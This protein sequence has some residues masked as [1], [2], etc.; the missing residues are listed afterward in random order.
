[1]PHFRSPRTQVIQIIRGGDSTN[2]YVTKILDEQ[3]LKRALQRRQSNVPLSLIMDNGQVRGLV[4]LDLMDGEVKA[5]QC[6]S[7]IL[8]VRDIKVSGRAYP[9]AQEMRSHWQLEQ[10]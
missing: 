10:G 7:V 4:T 3:L 2:R 5:F 6:K 1:M 8:H 9:R